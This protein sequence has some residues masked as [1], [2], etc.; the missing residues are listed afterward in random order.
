MIDLSPQLIAILMFG[1]LLT[2]VLTG[3]P[4]AFI[5]GSIGFIFGVLLFGPEV[6]SH[7]LYTRLYELTL[8]Y[9]YLAVPLFTFMGVVLQRSGIAEKLY[10]TLYESLSGFKG[11]LAVV[12]IIFGTV[13]AAC[14]GVITAA[15]TILTLIALSP[16][17]T[18]GY[19][20]ALASGTCV[21]GGTLGILIPPSIMLVVYGPQAGLSVGKMFMG[22]FFPGLILAALYAVYISGRCYFKPELGP[23]IPAEE[24]SRKTAAEKTFNLL[25]SLVPP[26]LLIFAV[27][28][29]IFLGIAPPTEA[30]A[31]GSLAAV[32]LA[33]VYKRFSWDLIK[34][35]AIETLRVSAFVV[36]IAGLC[37]AFVGVFMSAGCGDVVSAAIKAVPGGKWGS[38]LVIMMIVFALGMFIEWIGI[39]FIIV[40][41]FSPIFVELGFDPLWA[42]MMIC[43]N[44]QMAFQTPPMAMS[45]FVCQGTAPPELGVTMNHVVKGVLPFVLIIIFTLVLCTI[46]PGIITW[47]PSQMS[48]PS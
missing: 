34:H 16:M 1:S 48:G 5:I 43:I 13:L 12:T 18:R 45:I 26:V 8:N 38:F 46:F 4:I 42:G 10:E 7:I 36:L 3:F 41:I 29:T 6:A 32:L 25:K 2:L 19:D 23:P 37:Y 20:K 47:L 27:L 39:V 22:A 33:V 11:G 17:V 31:V 44:L 24:R 40:P 9:P 14:L 28:G 15:V 35:S 30:A 21:A